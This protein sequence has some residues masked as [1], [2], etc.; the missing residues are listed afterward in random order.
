M[1]ILA[2]DPGVTTGV[3]VFLDREKQ[4]HT[5][6]TKEWHDI[7]DLFKTKGIDTVVI[8]NFK[9]TTISTY[10]LHTVRLV[11]GMEALAYFNDVKYVVHQPQKRY[12]FMDMSKRIID[13]D[14]SGWVIHEADALGHLLAHQYELGVIKV[15]GDNSMKLYGTEIL[16]A[17]NPG[18][19]QQTRAGK[20]I[21]R[22]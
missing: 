10:G 12:A 22:R 4:Y 13:K 11:G 19:I 3:A 6:A 17:W 14:H 9:A 21:R 5:F 18:V 2:I 16:A 8:E 20:V 7:Y 1:N 15:Y